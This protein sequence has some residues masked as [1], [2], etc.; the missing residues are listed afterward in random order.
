MLQNKVIKTTLCMLEQA[1]EQ[2]A[3]FVEADDK[4]DFW[5]RCAPEGAIMNVG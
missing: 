1:F 4:R 3:F 5:H 2:V